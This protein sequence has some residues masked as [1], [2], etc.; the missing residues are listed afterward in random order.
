MRCKT[1]QTL[2]ENYLFKFMYSCIYITYQIQYHL[3]SFFYQSIL[4]STITDLIL[5]LY[6][7]YIKSKTIYCKYYNQ[8]QSNVTYYI[9]DTSTDLNCKIIFSLSN[10]ECYYNN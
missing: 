5:E 7:T 1:I 4:I 8:H 10:I 6:H 9:L 3:L 2:K